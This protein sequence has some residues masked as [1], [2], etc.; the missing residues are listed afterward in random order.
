MARSSAAAKARRKALSAL[1]ALD[2]AE[3]RKPGKRSDFVG[4]R[5]ELIDEFMQR[6]LGLRGQ[7]RPYHAIFWA[8]FFAKY[9]EMFHWSI[10]LTE[11]VPPDATLIV[12]SPEIEDDIEDE[13]LI[14][15][16]GQIIERTQQVRSM[17][18]IC[19][20]ALTTD[21]THT[22]AEI[23]LSISCDNNT[24]EGKPVGACL[25]IPKE[26]CGPGPST[27]QAPRFP[28]LYGQVPEQGRCSIQ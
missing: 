28:V 18:S 5:A 17:P 27:S 22:A 13:E 23:P 10:P 16:K 19:C 25:E 8:A 1:K 11:E 12:P 3:A 26:C 9:W 2:A 7:D 21:V 14:Q 20:A 24:P 15:M 4:R 6:Y